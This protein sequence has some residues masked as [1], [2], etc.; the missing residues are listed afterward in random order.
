V[1][2]PRIRVKAERGASVSPASPGGAPLPLG[3]NALSPERPS[4]RHC[5]SQAAL[6]FCIL[7][8]SF[9]LRFQVALEWLWGG[10]A[11]RSRFEVRGSG[12]DV[13][14]WMLDVRVPPH[15]PSPLRAERSHCVMQATFRLRAPRCTMGASVGLN[16]P[17]ACVYLPLSH[18]VL[19][20]IKVRA[21]RAYSRTP[22]NPLNP[23]TSPTVFSPPGQKPSRTIIPRSSEV[24]TV[25][26]HDFVP[27]HDKVVQEL[28]LRV[29]TAIDFR[30]GPE[31]GV[32]TKD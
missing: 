14:C 25:K 6:R 10:F 5:K 20:S 11:R 32:R 24:E 9:C 13:G 23:F 16:Y 31:L 7:H 19:L 18:A 15:P 22:C 2:A 3:L 28:L 8:S 4:H 21:A 12:F 26:V 1:R 29:L 17:T 27:H 30:Q